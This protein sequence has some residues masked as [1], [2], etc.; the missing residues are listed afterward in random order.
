MA[1]ASAGLSTTTALVAAGAAVLGVAVGY[2]IAAG[3]ASAAVKPLKGAA[4]VLLHN[5]AAVTDKAK[6]VKQKQGMSDVERWSREVSQGHH[7][8]STRARL[9]SHFFACTACVCDSLLRPMTCIETAIPVYRT[10]LLT[11]MLPVD[12]STRRANVA[13]IAACV[14]Q[15]R[16]HKQHA[17]PNTQH[18]RPRFAQ[19]LTPSPPSG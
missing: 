10:A 12:E 14:A 6:P 1:M 17:T 2:T 13:M 19:P 3:R 4:D 9:T 8:K 7:T 16:G 15:V 18:P 5:G 11:L